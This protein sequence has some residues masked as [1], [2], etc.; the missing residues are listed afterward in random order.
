MI[1]LYNLPV[2]SYGAK[3]RI[4]LAHYN[5]ADEVDRA[6]ACLGRIIG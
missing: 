3:V 5:T 4:I 2:S 6:L 1:T